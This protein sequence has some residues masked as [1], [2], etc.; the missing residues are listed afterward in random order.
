MFSASVSSNYVRSNSS[1]SF[2]GNENEGGLSY[3]YTLAFTRPW[4]NLFPDANGNY[5]DNP[6]YSG[7]PILV[8]DLAQNKDINNRFI[9]S[10]KLTANILETEKDRVKVTFSGGLDYLGN[11]TFVYV[12]EIHQAQRG[13]QNG[14]IGVG[15]N[16]FTFFKFN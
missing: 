4:I 1:R 7:N 6:N 2:T 15:K 11:E 13:N 14:F 5:P 10:V 12:P 9:Q 16:N 8:R 3:G